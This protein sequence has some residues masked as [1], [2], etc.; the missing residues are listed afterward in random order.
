VASSLETP[1]DITRL[2]GRTGVTV[3][4]AVRRCLF[5]TEEGVFA[6]GIATQGNRELQ[7]HIPRGPRL[8]LG[9]KILPTLNFIIR[10]DLGVHLTERACTQPRS[11]ARAASSSAVL[12]QFHAATL[13]LEVW[14]GSLD[15]SYDGG[16][17][18]APD[19]LASYS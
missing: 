15:S 7:E 11:P 1:N 3:R 16:H 14:F 6:G 8:L 12:L 9:E 13:R 18:K 5:W 2:L 17:C 4:R 10:E 19:H